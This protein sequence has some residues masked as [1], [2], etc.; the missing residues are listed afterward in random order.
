MRSE[1]QFLYRREIGVAERVVA[2]REVPMVR[3]DLLDASVPVHELNA[4][5]RAVVKHA[6]D[7][8]FWEPKPTGLPQGSSFCEDDAALAY[9]REQA[10][11]IRR[12]LEGDVDDFTSWEFGEARKFTFQRGAMPY[13]DVPKEPLIR[14]RATGIAAALEAIF[15]YAS[16]QAI[17]KQPNPVRR[18]TNHGGFSQSTSD[19]DMLLQGMIA[20]Y[21]VDGDDWVRRFELAYDAAATS[22]GGI[23]APCITQFSRTGP[24]RKPQQITSMQTGVAT[25]LG[26]A[27]GWAPRRR[28]VK[29]PPL[30]ANIVL[31][32]G[33][34]RL[35]GVIVALGLWHGDENEIAR[36]VAQAERAGWTMW[37]DDIS[38][39]D[40]NVSRDDQEALAVAILRVWPDMKEVV[41][42][43]LY[44]EQLPMFAPPLLAGEQARLYKVNGTTSSGL[45]WT[46][47]AG[48]LINVARV[49]TCHAVMRGLSAKEALT[50]LFLSNPKRA[51]IWGD[52]TMLALSADFSTER[53]DSV[54]GA[55]GFPC[56][57]ARGAAFLKKWYTTGTWIPSAARVFQQTAWNETGGRSWEI[58]CSGSGP[59]RSTAT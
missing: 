55:A 35:A 40:D 36:E 22:W 19:E 56:A 21:A 17:E 9:R 14:E 7:P 43:W 12:A 2:E 6:R 57:V 3:Q 50:E 27:T 13:W 25:L 15:A 8:A 33:Y 48:T 45:L 26:E 32:Q 34:G 39:F 18:H 31:R 23:K 24:I 51:W 1:W 38:S 20:A 41:A 5:Q 59:D 10:L 52:D 49:V 29:G 46:T 16:G 30:A 28:S 54:S 37:H 47:L 42:F 4:P 44:A 58:S 11:E 53:W